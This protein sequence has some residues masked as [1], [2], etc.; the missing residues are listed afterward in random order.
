MCLY[1]SVFRLSVGT[2]QEFTEQQVGGETVT[3][4]LP[5]L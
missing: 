4:T 5:S 1:I 3:A 2:D